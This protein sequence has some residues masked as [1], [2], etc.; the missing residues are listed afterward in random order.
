MQ[1]T[2][3]EEI[4]ARIA[5][6][7][8]KAGISQ[9]KVAAMLSA[10]GLLI[11]QSGIAKIE[12]GKRSLRASEM[13]PLAEVLG[14]HPIEFLDSDRIDSAAFSAGFDAGVAA[15]QEHTARYRR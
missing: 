2:E 11:A 12:L 1:L 5:A 4:G 9:A 13:V 6:C 7:R 3:D 14:A 8:E 10:R 15:V